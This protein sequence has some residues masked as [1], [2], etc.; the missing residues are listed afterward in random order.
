MP[1]CVCDRQA[2][3]V[4][5]YIAPQPSNPRNTAC[6]RFVASSRRIHTAIRFFS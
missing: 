5:G 2:R 4:A 3:S 6:P 1:E